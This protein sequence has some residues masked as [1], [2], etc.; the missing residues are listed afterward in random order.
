MSKP[1]RVAKTVEIPKPVFFEDQ[2]TVLQFVLFALVAYIA[3]LISLFLRF[4]NPVIWKNGFV[5][6]YGLAAIYVFAVIFVGRLKKAG[7]RRFKL[8]A[9]FL[10]L[11]INLSIAV[12]LGCSYLSAPEFEEKVALE[13]YEEVKKFV[14]YD[15]ERPADGENRQERLFEQPVE[16]GQEMSSDLAEVTQQPPTF[17]AAEKSDSQ[18]VDDPVA[19]SKVTPQIQKRVVETTPRFA[20]MQGTISRQS[21]ERSPQFSKPTLDSNPVPQQQQPTLLSEAPAK[22]QRTQ[23]EVVPDGVK[24][25]AELTTQQQSTDANIARRET[26]Q[27]PAEIASAEPTLDRQVLAPIIT[28]NA[29]IPDAD[30]NAVSQQTDR[31]AHEAADTFVRKQ[32]TASPRSRDSSEPLVDIPVQVRR[33]TITR[34]SPSEVVE[35]ARVD[36]T[37]AKRAEQNRTPDASEA[38][39]D[40]SNL[41]ESQSTQSD[42]IAAE[43]TEISKSSPRATQQIAPESP[44]LEQTARITENRIE[45]TTPQQ[46]QPEVA[47]TTAQPDQPER[48]AV[49]ASQVASTAAPVELEQTNAN[50]SEVAGDISLSP[51]AVTKSTQGISGSRE[52]PNFDS[53]SPASPSLVNSASASAKRSEAMQNLETG[54][55][56]SPSEVP[57]VKRATAGAAAPAASVFVILE[58]GNTA[59]GAEQAQTV[60]ALSPATT[61]EQKSNATRA[62]IT[63]Q[64]GE[65]KIDFGPTRI[66]SSTGKKSAAGG[67]QPELNMENIGTEF[68]RSPVNESPSSQSSAQV[69]TVP[70][71]PPQQQ[72]GASSGSNE[73][74]PNSTNVARQRAVQSASSVSKLENLDNATNLSARNLPQ[75]KGLTRNSRSSSS[76]A[77]IAELGSGNALPTRQPRGRPLELDRRAESV[78]I[79]SIT[80]STGEIESVPLEAQGTIQN[81]VA[82]GAPQREV[83]ELTGAL[84]DDEVFQG[85]STGR[86]DHSIQRRNL[87]PATTGDLA[88][89]ADNG[90]GVMVKRSRET[91]LPKAV[92]N[93]FVQEVPVAGTDSTR[94]QE[95]ANMPPEIAVA[96]EIGQLNRSS[97]GGLAVPIE[98]S[99]GVGGLATDHGLNVGVKRRNAIQNSQSITNAN[100]RFV[101]RNF[102]APPTVAIKAETA[103]AAFRNRMNRQ[104]KLPFV[105][106][107][108][109][110]QKTEKAIELGLIYLVRQQ[111]PDGSWSLNF[112]ANGRPFA[113]RERATI[114]SDAAATGLCL[115]SFLGAGYHHQNEKH[116]QVVNDALEFLVNHQSEDGN[117][118]IEQ[119]EESSKSARLYTHA[120]ACIALCEAYGM[121]QDP[122]LKDPAQRALNYIHDTQDLTRGGWRYVPRL[123]TDTSVTGWMMMALKSGQLAELE[124][125]PKTFRGIREWLQK[126]QTDEENSHG[127]AYNPL[128]KNIAGRLHGR[129]RSKTMTAVGLLM[130][131]YSGWKRDRPEMILGGE[132]LLK[133]LPEIGDPQNPQRDTYYWYY[134]TQVMFQLGG[135]YW[136]KWNE[137]LHPLLVDSQIETGA[138]AGSWDPLLPIPDRWAVHGGR[139]YVTTMNLLSLEVF[140]RHLPIYL[141][142]DK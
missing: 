89:A 17:T 15:L 131:L 130:R 109:P 29:S 70:T 125:D 45:R 56:L 126:A 59:A 127:Y 68:S 41:A 63:A 87:S 96:S 55:A 102:G 46:Q 28:P 142:P 49:S 27:Q 82:S 136:E 137:K 74:N 62:P 60:D 139:L 40:L 11:I 93:V 97:S 30:R 2:E 6:L 123:G 112:Q 75:A 134:A 48:S 53:Q 67:G 16:T 84:A 107:K 76:V 95:D 80:Q 42:R 72:T 120:I 99:E 64:V 13:E 51:M 61:V 57:N 85:R 37:T 38:E 111:L 101:R 104:G 52:Q 86:S 138:D 124:T 5:Y 23:S 12:A 108:Q 69:A 3:V 32:E 58:E 78:Q 135:E 116:D 21:T 71:S 36:Q 44:E 81:R 65:A 119:D 91:N 4:D 92:E 100:A 114:R 106:S 39:V 9:F 20:D 35:I 129:R 14:E 141:E 132:Y 83:S 33:R 66:A 18:A 128:A 1:K 73:L 105:G 117:L 25:D 140:Y 110:S 90:G 133:N 122:W 26:E 22:L 43:A 47:N 24:S 103:T 34:N 7:I 54:P 79:E 98:A 115:L 77:E 19:E 88:I 8:V 50:S 31:Q 118:Y 113:P 121:T 10:S 94:P